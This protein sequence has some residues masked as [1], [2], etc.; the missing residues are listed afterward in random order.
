MRRPTYLG[1]LACVWLM[2][3]VG[4]E[5]RSESSRVDS[6]PVVTDGAV[7]VEMP[8]LPPIVLPA[9]LKDLDDPTVD[10]WGTE[11]F[12]KAVEGQF[13]QMVRLLADPG[14]IDV[15]A[16]Q[17]LVA[18]NF[19]CSPLRPSNL[20]EVFKGPAFTVMREKGPAGARQEGAG[21]LA[22]A[23]EG[24]VEPFGAEV[25]LEIKIVRVDGREPT[26]TTQHV[27]ISGVT[28]AGAME[29]HAVWQC[30]W[31]DR[32][33][34]SPRLLSVTVK[35][36]EQTRKTGGGK[37]FADCTEAVLGS[38]PG[39]K[40]QLMH[41]SFHWVGQME[42]AL[43]S[44]F[45]G[46]SGLAVGDVNG[47]GL[48]DVY[49]CQS[50]GLPNL[51]LIQNED[52]TVT[53]RAAQSNV[54]WADHTSS[55]LLLDLDNDGDQDLVVAMRQVVLLMSND[56]AGR[57]RRRR[58]LRTPYGT[59]S[60]TA[61]DYDLDGYVD[62]YIS[63]NLPYRVLQANLSPPIPYHDANNGQSNY[64]YRNDS[65][66][67]FS[68]VTRETGMD[69]DNLRWSS[70][71]GWEDFDHD[72]D[73]D[74][75][76]AND[77]GRNCF[78][79]NDVPEG[80]RFVNVAEEKGVENQAA[81]TSVSWADYDHDGW[82]DL[83]VGNVFSAA[84]NRVAF[85][86]QFQPGVSQVVRSMMRGMARGGSLLR[87]NGH[88]MFH[89]VS[90]AAGVTM[91]RWA[92]SSLFTDLNNDGWDDLVVANGLWTAPD[93][94]DLQ[95]FFWRQVVSRS[96]AT[97]VDH[98]SAS[99]YL[100]TMSQLFELRS[101]GRSMGGQ[102][103]NCAYLNTGGGTA[104]ESGEE[105][106]S[107]SRFANV[108]ATSGLD[109]I[110]D[111]R[112]VASVD[113]DFDGDLDLWIAN[114][115]APQL[116]FVRNDA[117]AD[118]HFLLLRL[119]GKLCN[120]DAIGARVEV[121]LGGGARL[122]KS[123]QAGGGFLAQSSKWVHFGLGEHN[124]IEE[125][126]VYW[127]GG[128]AETFGSVD[129]DH[130]YRLVQGSRQAKYLPLIKPVVELEAS[131]LKG[132]PPSNARRAFLT[133]RVPVPLLHYTDFD[134]TS[135]NL[136]ENITGPTVL[137]LWASWSPPCISQLESWTEQVSD[138]GSAGL[139]VVTLSVDGMDESK[140]T[141]AQD[142]KDVVQRMTLP[143]ERGLAGADLV[144]KLQ[145]LHDHLFGRVIAPTVPFSYLIDGDG[146][147][148]AIYR[149]PVGV[150]QL[151]EDFKRLNLEPADRREFSS[152]FGG[153]WF[154]PPTEVDLGPLAKS[155]EAAGHLDDA[156]RYNRHALLE[157]EDD[158]ALRLS[159]ADRLQK[160]KQIAEA[161]RIY[162]DVAQKRPNSFKAQFRRGKFYNTQARYREALKPLALAARLNPDSAQARTEMGFALFK[163]GQT[164][165]AIQHLREAVRLDSELA[166]ARN[167][168][169]VIY[170][171]QDKPDL[172]AKHLRHAVR[173]NPQHV[174]S[175]FNLAMALNLV[176]QSDEAISF[177]HKA[178]ELAKQQEQGPLI[179]QIRPQLKAME[180]AA[181]QRQ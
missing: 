105:S 69:A 97:A 75:Y 5:Q 89:D 120:R 1:F 134:N 8:E 84:G 95:S 112:A 16:V 78:Y 93:P 55:A 128:T 53:D 151:L 133:A 15:A 110:D 48:T 24:L 143:F 11:V 80:G 20:R 36:F 65:G 58:S 125:L 7:D 130:R 178:L 153:R 72:G 123:L 137:N 3:S 30:A 149:G 104:G 122:I 136:N 169:G 83:Y 14:G 113:W 168:L 165:I 37:L 106:G 71:A 161:A 158:W 166:S 22:K 167:N 174:F 147:L 74:L 119:E 172:A 115:T 81:G 179:K 154:D 160:N 140:S 124:A 39:F 99:D 177:C 21:A 23:L 138:F 63:R 46:H 159:L 135:R 142:G 43:D 132:D 29:E 64:L 66:F 156:I 155:F 94:E 17:F 157:Q 91:G 170:L 59:S 41:G 38:D 131:T 35:D 92:W 57:F 152:V 76:V 88:G 101:Y 163:V 102:E 31:E 117:P 67:G 109:F 6:K 70:A 86:S 27:A 51:L 10:G 82:V 162:K 114:R 33:D 45:T 87:N 108:S 141:T 77:F 50:G 40:N 171:S 19:S 126:V 34:T 54:D 56:G 98:E 32:Q 180:R 13:K 118:S 181:A 4:C 62:L 44:D 2:L 73:S 61:A 139:R 145:V 176:G 150:K 107:G 111:A 28:A 18:D 90:K 148:A 68:D 49:V 60:L 144:T 52:G 129:P 121:H 9:S 96:P 42:A 12:S 85:Q 173:L 164:P 79:R 47:D 103:R 26:T 100:K 25:E 127:P 116:R 175:H 146:Q